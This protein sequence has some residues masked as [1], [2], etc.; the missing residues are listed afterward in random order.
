MLPHCM[1][2]THHYQTQLTTALGRIATLECGGESCRGERGAQDAPAETGSSKNVTN[3]KSHEDN[4]RHRNHSYHHC[5]LSAQ[6]PTLIDQ[7]VAAALSGTRWQAKQDG[8]NS[9]GSGSGTKAKEG[10]C[11]TQREALTLIS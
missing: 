9:H 7:G 6:T 8:D 2:Q 11:L 4:T 1:L 10:K 3:K 5:S